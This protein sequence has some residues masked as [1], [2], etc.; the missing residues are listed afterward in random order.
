MKKLL[1]LLLALLLPL[2]GLAIDASQQ[3]VYDVLPLE[4]PAPYAYHPEALS[5]DGLAYEDDSIAVRFET[6]R[7]FDT[8]IAVAHVS[9]RD[10]SQ[11]R[12]GLAA[13]K[14]PSKVT[15]RVPDMAEDNHAVLAVNGDYFSYRDK[16]IIKRN[17]QVLRNNPDKA[18][19]LLMVDRKGDFIIVEDPSKSDKA[20]A[21]SEDIVHIFS[22]GP[23]LVKDG[24]KRPAA[25][26][27][28]KKISIDADKGHVRVCIGQTGPLSYVVF[29]C[30]AKD[31]G[32][33]NSKGL[34]IMQAA[35]VAEALGCSQAYN[36]DG[37]NSAWMW[38]CGKQ[39]NTPWKQGQKVRNVSDI[40]YFATLIPEVDAQ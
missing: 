40:I 39:L 8:N 11:F 4:G 37:G 24:I 3:V 36:L 16:G 18:F 15:R 38:L 1:L 29:I 7:M 27:P 35:D 34:S 9:I 17:G 22:F 13:K 31:A 6:I 10:A 28:Y 26:D 2:E 14:F 23:Y 20:L 30:E 12:T 21:E 33:V 5:E 25:P 32:H 19:D